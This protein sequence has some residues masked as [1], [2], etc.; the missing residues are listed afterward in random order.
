MPYGRT[1]RLVN[2]ALCLM[3]SERRVWTAEEIRRTV[4]GYDHPES[5]KGEAA[6]RR[7]FERDKD[8][9]RSLG[10]PLELVETPSGAEG[11]RIRRTEAFLPEVRL[12]AEE[13]RAVALA[14][15]MWRSGTLEHAAAHAWT[16]LYAAGIDPGA[17]TRGAGAGAG[18]RPDADAPPDAAVVAAPSAPVGGSDSASPAAPSGPW[19]SSG[20]GPFDEVPV[21][22]T[23][24]P[25][26][27]P[28]LAALTAAAPVAFDYRRRG[29]PHARTRV[30]E[31][32]GLRAARG[33]WYLVGLDRDRGAARVFRLSRIVGTVQRAG[34]DGT[35]QRPDEVDLRVELDHAGESPP[36]TATVR[37]RRG[38]AHEVRRLAERFDGWY[39]SYTD[40]SIST[41]SQA[42]PQ[43]GPELSP[44]TE[45][46][47]LPFS[48]ITRA[49]SLLASHGADA[50]VLEPADLR[51]EVV[52]LLTAQASLV[53]PA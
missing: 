18:A 51:E 5:P 32:W 40:T 46:V 33:R 19:G 4:P 45:T 10:F 23:G 25:A 16:K 36:R 38:R 27:D 12:D 28:L 35:V 50:V 49:A 20:E 3:S 1:E 42:G 22:D 47:R 6:F 52:A 39:G 15:R 11:Y 30:V 44:D 17:G 9:L 21:V 8:E 26:F 29:E 14:V 13:A 48:D 41:G 37:L 31:P 34:A 7:A 53:R 43:D 2:L 24:E